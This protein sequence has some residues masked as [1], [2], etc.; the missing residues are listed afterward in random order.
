MV[1]DV[2]KYKRK[3]GVDAALRALA[4]DMFAG[5]TQSLDLRAALDDLDVRALVIWGAQDQ[6]I[7]VSHAE[8]L[9]GHVEVHVLDGRGHSPHME[10]AGDC[11][12]LIAR[13]IDS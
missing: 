6:I 13:L 4:G 12:R 9:P 1:D 3:D 2:L 7:P 11:N 8:H 10:A 5:G